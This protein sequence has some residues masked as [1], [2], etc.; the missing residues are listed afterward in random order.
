MATVTTHHLPDVARYSIRPALVEARLITDKQ[1]GDARYLAGVIE[2]LRNVETKITALEEAFPVGS[3]AVLSQS[4]CGAPVELLDAHWIRSKSNELGMRL[5]RIEKSFD[6][7]CATEMA[8][9]S[10]HPKL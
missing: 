7:P 5:R 2:E 6:P 9:A 1:A 4:T 10:A 3:S 8:L